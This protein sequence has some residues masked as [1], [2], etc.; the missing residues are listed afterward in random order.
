MSLSSSLILV[1]NFD[2]LTGVSSPVAGESLS[3]FTADP[4]PVKSTG[5]VGLAV[6]AETSDVVGAVAAFDSNTNGVGSVFIVWTQANG[7]MDSKVN[8]GVQLVIGD[9]TNIIGFHVS[10]SDAAA[11]RH[12]DGPVKWEALIIDSSNLPLNNTELAG[13]LAA[14]NWGAITQVGAAFKTLSKAVG[15]VENCFIGGAYYRIKNDTFGAVNP[16]INPFGGTSGVPNNFDKIAIL[17]RSTSHAFAGI[18]EKGTGVYGAQLGMEFGVNGADSYFTDKNKFIIFEDR[19]LADNVFNLNAVAFTGEIHEIRLGTK[20]G[21][22][23]GSEGVFFITPRGVGNKF[24]FGIVDVG[25]IPLSTL[26]MYGGGITGCNKGVNFE[27]DLTVGATH[28]VMDYTFID[29]GMIDAGAIQLQNSLITDFAD[30]NGGLLIDDIALSSRKKLT[31]RSVGSR[32]GVYIDVNAPVSLTLDNWQ[33]ENFTG[34][35]GSN[36]VANSGSVDAAIFNDSGKAI[37]ITP[38]NGGNIPSVRNGA[39][40]TTTVLSGVTLAITVVNSQTLLPIL[41][42]QTS[43]HLKDSPFTELLNVD[44]DASGLATSAY[45]GSTGVDIV[46]KCRKSEIT[47]DPRYF[48]QSGLGSIENNGFTLDVALEKNP[49]I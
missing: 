23:G 17:D 36:L 9:G 49:F 21:A 1:N 3:V 37:T 16:T 13:T 26:L 18:R 48:G 42:A 8:G 24:N 27:R 5:S 28:E 22:D 6:S 34:T 31:F 38:I 40:A 20:V 47:D 43:I 29:N 14:L 33:F 7:T 39:G 44:T 45:T 46:W 10:G 35:A 11:F 4:D 41:N 15:G 2:S 32:H 12:E 25:L 19:G 30:P